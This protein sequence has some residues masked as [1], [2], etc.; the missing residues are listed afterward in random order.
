MIAAGDTPDVGISRS[1]WIESLHVSTIH[2]VVHY[3]QDIQ[4]RL[5]GSDENEEEPKKLPI[6]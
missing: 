6:T 3:F 1:E 2:E 4:G 5:T